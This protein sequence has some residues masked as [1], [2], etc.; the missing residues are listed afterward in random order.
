MKLTGGKLMRGRGRLLLVLALALAAGVAAWQWQS[1]WVPTSMPTWVP[2]WVSS[3][4][5]S[6]APAQAAR[7][8]QPASPPAVPVTSGVAKID[9][10][11]VYLTGLGTVQAFNTV[12]VKVRVDGE[13]DKVAFTEG[14]DVKANDVLAQIDPRPFQAALDQAK[15]TQAKDE[16][17][18]ANAKVDLKRFVDLGQYATRQSVDTQ[19]ALVRQL[20]A[21]V[22]ADKAAVENAQVQLDYTTVRAP[23]SGRT[24]L[25]LVDAG[26]IVHAADPNGLVVI[27]QLQPISVVF[28]LP[29]DQLQEVMKGMAAGSLKVLAAERAKGRVL[30][31]GTLALVDNQIDTSTGTVRLKATFPNTDYGLWPGQF[32][33]AR[34]L[35]R[36]LQKVVTVP[37]TAIQRGPDG[38]YVYVIKPDSTVAMQPVNVMQMTGGS[39]VIQSGLDAGT[40]VV[41]AGQYRLQSGSHVQIQV[42]DADKSGGT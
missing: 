34:L 13:L 41:I 38:M 6:W 8:R 32:V 2:T 26:N 12:T 3:W 42:A 10:V 5:P 40:K 23:I 28:T 11:P 37:S 27:T 14:Q 4:A 9:N 15:A 30:E 18:L 39:S 17:Q 25:R 33:D 16:A 20:D 24:G 35:V 36:T 22:Q 7:Q 19:T 1:A 21:Q 31:E 29:E